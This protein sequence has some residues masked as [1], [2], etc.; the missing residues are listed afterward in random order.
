ME[1]G[2]LHTC[3]NHLWRCSAHPKSEKMASWASIASSGAPE[4]ASTPQFTTT[5]SQGRQRP[6]QRQQRGGLSA[7]SPENAQ[8]FQ[9]VV[10]VCAMT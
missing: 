7:M 8:I 6:A 3:G 10:Q 2:S 4:G 9:Q 5:Q 1:M